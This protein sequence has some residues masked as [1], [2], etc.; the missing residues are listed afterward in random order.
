M[1]YANAYSVYTYDT[2]DTYVYNFQ[3]TCIW[4]YCH[5]RPT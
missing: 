2:Y 5:G 4:I 3:K 1:T